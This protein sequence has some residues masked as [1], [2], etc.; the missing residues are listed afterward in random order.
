MTP[1]SIPLA[2]AIP[3]GT[4]MAQGLKSLGQLAEAGLD[5]DAPQRVLQELLEEV[6]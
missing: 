1:S 6:P 4:A 3:G 5:P 2:L